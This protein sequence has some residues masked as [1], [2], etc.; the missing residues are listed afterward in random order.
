M[1]TISMLLALGFTTIGSSAEVIIRST[2]EERSDCVQSYELGAG[3]SMISLAC[4]AEDSAMGTLFPTATALFEFAPD[5]GY[6]R[7]TFLEPG[8]GYW[9]NM[10]APATVALAG[11]PIHP[12]ALSTPAGWSMIGPCSMPAMVADLKEATEDNLLAAFGFDAGYQPV[13][14][15]QPGRG[16]WMKLAAAGVLNLGGG[17]IPPPESNDFTIR[18]NPHADQ[19]A[20]RSFSKY[21]EVFGLRIYAEDRFTEAQVL[22]VAKVLAE[23]LDNDEDGAVDDAALLAQLQNSGFIMPMFNRENSTAMKDFMR[24]YRGEGISAVLFADEVDPSRPG[25]WGADATIEEIM[26]TINHRAHVEIYPEAFGLEPGSSRLTEAM[27]IARGG[28]FLSVPATYPDEAW[29]HYD[30]ETCDYQ[31]MAI[32]YIYWA[33]VTNMDL[34]AD[35]A[36]CEGI[37]HEWEP[38]SKTLLQKM[39][40]LI[41]ELVT[42]P[43]YK[44][45]QRAPN[46]DYEP[47][48]RLLK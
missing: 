12:C 24:H 23:L 31:C 29:Y 9:I 14:T 6:Q 10:P 38:C 7:A 2:G 44:L 22:H 37:A 34:L 21:V 46:G 27:D 19:P 40:K 30:D 41:F 1:P 33:Q 20:M 18:A 16:Y 32:E 28:Q 13:T 5:S 17:E 25:R 26:H 15:L 39:D 45:P 3:C 48:A 36:T 42:D 4:K 35:A 43:A 11:V 8:K 47:A